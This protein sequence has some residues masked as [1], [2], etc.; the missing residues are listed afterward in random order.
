MNRLPAHLAASLLLLLAGCASQPAPPSTPPATTVVTPA[1]IAAVP[2][3]APP[4]ADVAVPDAAA[5]PPAPVSAPPATGV[6]SAAPAT[7]TTLQDV[8]DNDF[9]A[10]YGGN[11]APGDSEEA[12]L[13]PWQPLNR[14]VHAF[15]SVIDQHLMR[16][17]AQAYVDVLPSPLRAGISNVFDNL[18]APLAFGNLLLQGRPAEAVETLGRFVVNS[19][20]GIGGIFDPATKA[21]KMHRHGA[22]F[23]R[24]LARWGWQNSR[25]LEL[26]FLGPRT[27]RD[28]VGAIGDI[29]LSP[30]T[31]I[32]RDRVRLP[33]EALWTVD[34]RS[35]LLSLDALRASAPDEYV[36]TRDAWLARRRYLVDADRSARDEGNESLPAYLLKDIPEAKPAPPKP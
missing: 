29:G 14:R 36:L 33:L 35:K 30:M 19:I 13:D 24:T 8:V 23:G 12:A 32:Q 20:I 15:N 34:V 18:A 17:V 2:D 26:P 7:G 21:L 4:M 22:D 9:D 25:Y 16:P 28:A 27:V 10:I 11:A 3:T 31:H 6:E 5:V 1:A